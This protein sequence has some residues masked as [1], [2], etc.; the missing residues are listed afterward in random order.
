MLD[1]LYELPEEQNVGGKY[2]L[3]AAAIER[4]LSLGELRRAK[5]ESA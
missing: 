2:V 4:R 1:L 5:K 3:D